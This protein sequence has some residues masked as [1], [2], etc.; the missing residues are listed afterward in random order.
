MSKIKAAAD[1]VSDEGLLPDLQMAVF[2]FYLHKE[3]SRG[4]RK[5]A[6]CLLLGH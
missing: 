5:Q 4:E 1:A 6:P 3:K 2:S